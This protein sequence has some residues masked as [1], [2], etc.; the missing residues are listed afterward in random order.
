VLVVK[1][2]LIVSV[3]RGAWPTESEINVESPGVFFWGAVRWWENVMQPL[4]LV[5]PTT[6]RDKQKKKK[7]KKIMEKRRTRDAFCVLRF[8]LPIA[9]A[10]KW[11]MGKRCGRGRCTGGRGMSTT[12]RFIMSG[13]RQNRREC[14]WEWQTE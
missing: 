1:L 5:F 9:C 2:N 8:L 13:E 11:E 12:V 4:F 10:G 6:D 14:D 7:R 3:A